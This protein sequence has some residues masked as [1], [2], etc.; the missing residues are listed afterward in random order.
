MMSGPKA[1]QILRDEGGSVRRE[2]WPRNHAIRLGA[3]PGNGGEETLLYESPDKHGVLIPRPA[4]L[5]GADI[6][7]TDW[8]KA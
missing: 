8:E 5:N 6:R 2:D 7:S 1:I 3:W 4:I